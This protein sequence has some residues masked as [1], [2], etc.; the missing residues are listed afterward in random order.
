MRLVPEQVFTPGVGD[1]LAIL[2]RAGPAVDFQQIADLR[3]VPLLDVLI[4]RLCPG[5]QA[6][7]P[8]HVKEKKK[9]AIMVQRQR[10]G[11]RWC[12]LTTYRCSSPSLMS[13]RRT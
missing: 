5:D 7:K 2:R 9:Q 6:G 11:R 10:E 8:A 13:C 4:I 3:T 12:T 1:L